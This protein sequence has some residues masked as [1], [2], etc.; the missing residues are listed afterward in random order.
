MDTL[1]ASHIRRPSFRRALRETGRASARSSRATLRGAAQAGF[2]LIEMLIVAAILSALVAIAVPRFNRYQTVEEAKSRTTQMAGTL[3]DTRARALAEG[4]Q[5]FIVFDP[6]AGT[7]VVPPGNPAIAPGT[8]ARIVVDRDA[9]WRETAGDTAENVIPAQRPGTAVSTYGANGPSPFPGSRVIATDNQT[10]GATLGAL[11]NGVN[12]PVD[13]TSGLRAVGF[14]PRGL[15]VRL[16]PPQDVGTGAG[17][18]YVTD[19]AGAVF[20]ATIGTLGEV[21]IRALDPTQDQWR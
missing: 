8:V 14:T 20:A 19:N 1:Q 5:R 7:Y 9:N 17:S 13:P 16:Q 15:P 21:R 6:V 11:G 4:I 2:S 3:R 10:L 18:Y 12:F